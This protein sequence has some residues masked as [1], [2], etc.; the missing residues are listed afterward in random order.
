[1][2]NYIG[3]QYEWKQKTV[4]TK[5]QINRE[6]TQTSTRLLIRNKKQQQQNH[7]QIEGPHKRPLD[8]LLETKNSNN[9]TTNK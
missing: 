1:M 2:S 8:Y 9:K 5:P 3:W 7:K 6:T 4:T